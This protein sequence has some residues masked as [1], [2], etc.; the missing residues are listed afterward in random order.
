MKTESQLAQQEVAE[1]DVPAM[2]ESLQSLLSEISTRV[3]LADQR[4]TDIIEEMRGKLATLDAVAKTTRDRAE[5]EARREAETK[6]RA[7]EEAKRLADA[8]AEAK[9]V[10]EEKKRIEAEAAAKRLLDQEAARKKAE[11]D[12]AEAVEAAKAAAAA[13]VATRRPAYADDI[14]PFDIIDHAPVRQQREP[15]DRESADVFTR[16]FEQ[17]TRP[18]ADLPPSSGATPAAEGTKQPL[19]HRS[20]RDWLD[21]RFN[22]I[23][24]RISEMMAAQPN[25]LAARFDAMETRIETAMTAVSANAASGS[26]TLKQIEG[27]IAEIDEH[28]DFIRKELTR[29]DGMEAQI[30]AVIEIQKSAPD[31][32]R[33][34][35]N[36]AAGADG[37]LTGLP[38]LTGL[39][40]RLM[41]ERRSTEEHT[42]SMLDTLQQAMIRVLD[43]IEAME[44]LQPAQH[45][46]PAQP[47]SPLDALA[48]PE[49]ARAPAE[50][51][52]GIAGQVAS[53]AAEDFNFIDFE[54][55]FRGIDVA[56]AGEVTQDVAPHEHQPSPQD[57]RRN[58]IANAQ[59]AR[60]RASGQARRDPVTDTA[61]PLSARS[62][63]DRLLRPSSK[64]L[65]VAAVALL[66]PLN[67]FFLYLIVAAPKSDTQ[68]GMRSA[69]EQGLVPAERM[70]EASHAEA[71]EPPISPAPELLT[72]INAPLPPEPP[73]S[74]P[75]VAATP[76]PGAKVEMPPAAIG[77]LTLR[78]A[79]ADGDASA[80][81][82]VAAR[83]AEGKGI[84][85]D[86]KG[87]VEWYLRSAST[88]FAQAQ[89]RLG[90]HY[91]RG[92]GVD[93]DPE[94]ARAWY[95]RAAEQ[96]NVKA[97]H[98]LAVID[99]GKTNYAD[100]VRWFT[101]AASYNLPDSQF[102]LAVLLE[103]GLSGNKDVKQAYVWF[104]LAARGGDKEAMKRRDQVKGQL[105]ADAVATADEEVR[106]FRAKAQIPV[107][108]DARVAGE[109]WKKTAAN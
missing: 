82:E 104:A 27:H 42:V 39:L 90:T 36:Q 96:G 1:G 5:E 33:E 15:W 73:A 107:V 60:D 23:A 59:R 84:D 89:Y 49:F 48:K 54:D 69:A 9:R 61:A 18:D 79:A 30:R 41:A 83:L 2:A 44:A 52:H 26:D 58:F 81:F 76:T 100:A 101:E 85:Q 4:Y 11:A 64:Q 99:A 66:L 103:G 38:Q 25:N 98:N 7:E 12:A 55:E 97:M 32:P 57:I 93:R 108:N 51:E 63:V 43:R 78:R 95:Q 67:V 65:A 22:D 68:A 87:A 86:F 8:E 10:A 40:Q 17:F 94:R 3:S 92:L 20:D 74:P 80:Q 35:E 47:G 16:H 37:D 34:S 71:S 91:E 62:M 14:D 77:P 31:K 46:V 29:L 75:A 53:A 72:R 109:A 24:A 28:V 19:E 70:S 6:K 102:N 13:V 88:G 105:S 21:G 45:K 106:S 56:V 50:A